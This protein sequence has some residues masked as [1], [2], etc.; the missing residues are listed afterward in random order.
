MRYTTDLVSGLCMRIALAPLTAAWHNYTWAEP[1]LSQ[2]HCKC[3]S[4]DLNEVLI[5]A[6]KAPFSDKVLQCCILT[7]TLGKQSCH[8]QLYMEIKASLAACINS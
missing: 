2:H 6:L 7:Y 8:A 3:K 1:A 4:F 5:T